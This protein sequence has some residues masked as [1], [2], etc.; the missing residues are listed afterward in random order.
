MS[1]FELDLRDGVTLCASHVPGK[2]KPYLGISENGVFLALAE[3]ISDADLDY[4]HEVF[5]SRVFIIQP[6]ATA[7]TTEETPE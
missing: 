6:L 4:L 2:K 7:P 5:K 1:G 3:F